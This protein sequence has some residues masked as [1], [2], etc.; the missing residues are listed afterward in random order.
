MGTLIGIAVEFQ[1]GA[2]LRAVETTI[3]QEPGLARALRIVA[4]QVGA[5][6]LRPHGPNRREPIDV[7][8][9]QPVVGLGARDA[10]LRE[11]RTNSLRTLA[12]RDARANE[13]VRKTRVGQ[14]ARPLELVEH[15]RDD[16]FAKT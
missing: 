3:L 14:Q 10:T 4:R 2:D 5:E 7:C 1:Y 6:A 12:P 13:A 15:G 16:L 11:L 9:A 8:G